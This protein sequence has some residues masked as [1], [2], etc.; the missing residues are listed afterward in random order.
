MNT[1]EL[2]GILKTEREC[3]M[4]DCDRDCSKC[5][6]ALP[7][8][9]PIVE[10]LTVAI[11]ELSAKVSKGYDIPSMD[12][13]K[14]IMSLEVNEVNDYFTFVE[15]NGPKPFKELFANED[16]DRVQIHSATPVHP[17]GMIAGFIGVFE[18]ENNEIRSLDGDD[19]SDTMLVYGYDRFDNGGVMNGLSILVA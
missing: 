19:Y 16:F 3:V 18:W 6:L 8:P 4:R 5:E 7:S 17:S 13:V 10:A 2:I 9:E 11:D 15:G 12:A 14:G 1:E